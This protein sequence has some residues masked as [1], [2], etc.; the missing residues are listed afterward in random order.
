FGTLYLESATFSGILPLPLPEFLKPGRFGSVYLLIELQ[1]L[2]FAA[3]FAFRQVKNGFVALFTGRGD[4]DSVACLA[5]LSSAVHTLILLFFFPTKEGYVLFGSISVFL[6]LCSVLRALFE[7]GANTLALQTLATGDVK[8]AAAK[9]GE[10]SPELE[11]FSDYVGEIVPEVYSVSRGKFIDGF[12]RRV[13]TQKKNTAF[14][15]A[16]PL[17]LLVSVGIGVWCYLGGGEQARLY[18]LSAFSCSMMMGLPAA[19]IFSASLPF[20]FASRQAAK[21][22]TALLGEAA[23]NEA[24]EAEIVSFDDNEVFLPKYV[25]VTSVRTYGNARIDRVLIHCAQIF[26][27]VGGPLSF[28]FENSISSLSVPGVVEILENNGDGIC[29]RIDGKEIYL[30]GAAYMESYEF[31][32]ELDENDT[33]YENTVGR[34]MY[35]AEDGELAA[36]FYIKYAVSARFCAQL[37]ALNRAGIYAVIK[38]CDPNVD[39]ALL[40]KILGNPSHPIAVIKTGDAAQNAKITEHLDAPIAGSGKISAVLNGFLL[41]EGVRG[42]AGFGT[43][44]NFVSTLLGLFIT[45]FL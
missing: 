15:I 29:A 43:L 21:T 13:D 32:I 14:T 8:Y 33:T 35:F 41:C 42:R 26:R 37:S 22:S 11:A 5:L 24:C 18:A 12:L 16:L 17:T 4:S 28:V 36:K 30:G 9:T 25:K 7:H 39:A 20:F 6:A 2:V 40:Q 10:G 44:V 27:I 38:T 19:G 34:I 45:F 3:A 31:P 23:V 1:L